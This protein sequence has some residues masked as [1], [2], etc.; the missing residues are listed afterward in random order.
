VLEAAAWDLVL[1]VAVAGFR[2][3]GGGGGG[4]C[5]EGGCFEVE[6]AV[7][8]DVAWKDT[9]RADFIGSAWPST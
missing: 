6:D 5:F 8:F 9:P 3:G 2:D 4:G 1:E 7:D